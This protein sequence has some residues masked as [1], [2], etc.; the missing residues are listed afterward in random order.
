M[1]DRPAVTRETCLL[2]I[3]LR[4]YSSFFRCSLP[5]LARTANEKNFSAQRAPSREERSPATG[6]YCLVVLLFHRVRVLL[7]LCLGA[8]KAA[9]RISLVKLVCATSCPAFPFCTIGSISVRCSRER[10]A[11]SASAVDRSSISSGVLSASRSFVL[12]RLAAN[13]ASQAPVIDRSYTPQID[14]LE[15]SCHLLLF[16]TVPRDRVVTHHPFARRKRHCLLVS[17]KHLSHATE[18]LSIDP[19]MRFARNKGG[20]DRFEMHFIVRLLTRD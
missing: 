19:R 1:I 9:Q 12:D 10:V 20:N 17:D 7:N 11:R 14:T 5:L 15:G 6:F 18:I 13:N 8:N 2:R 3:A 16:V 4:G